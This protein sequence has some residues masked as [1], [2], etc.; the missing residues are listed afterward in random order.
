MRVGFTGTSSGMTNDQLL[1]VH[2]LLGDLQHYAG[3]TQATHGMCIGADEQFHD[4]AKGFGY[5]TIGLPGV[6]HEG[7]VWKR[8]E[9]CQCD[10]VLPE[11]FFLARNQAIVTE[12]DVI[13]ATPKQKVEQFRGSG[14]WSTI[15]YA[16]K[17]K[18][19]LIIV[20]PDGSGV[21]ERVKDATTLSAYRELLTNSL[22][23][24]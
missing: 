15:R 18:R 9:K 3:A 16:R 7:K 11:R 23:V 12:S 1:Q 6:T 8:S 14:T 20:W 19:R 13:I 24:R 2:M 17:D 21:V 10:L 4:Q 5:F 22:T